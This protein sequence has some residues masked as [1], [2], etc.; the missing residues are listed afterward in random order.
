MAT[1]NKTDI[2]DAKE[3]IAMELADAR[4]TVIE[5]VQDV[6]AL[7]VRGCSW[8]NPSVSSAKARLIAA[9]DDVALL[10]LVAKEIGKSRAPAVEPSPVSPLTTRG[11]P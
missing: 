6:R 2:R 7:L 4:E 1:D 10:E 3:R 5:R 11:A 9:L 8:R